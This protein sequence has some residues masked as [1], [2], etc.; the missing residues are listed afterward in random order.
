MSAWI[1]AKRKC[2]SVIK[3]ETE[4]P[5]NYINSDKTNSKRYMQFVLKLI[6][7]DAQS[8]GAHVVKWK[9]G[10]NTTLYC[11][12]YCDKTSTFALSPSHLARECNP[13]NRKYELTT[14]G[15]F[16]NCLG[17]SNMT[18]S[19]NTIFFGIESN[20]NVAIRRSTLR[21]RSVWVSRH[22]VEV[23]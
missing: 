11:I 1:R 19:H 2:H 23:S 9:E 18:N 6:I 8:N 22:E 12:F 20:L 15:S 17:N 5:E 16:E 14:D 3:K 7:D 13:K 21:N 10:W 4:M